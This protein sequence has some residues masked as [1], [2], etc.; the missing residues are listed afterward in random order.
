MRVLVVYAHPYPGSFCHAVLERV[1]SG[2][3]DAG[4]SHEVIDLHRSRFDPVFRNRDYNQFMHESLPD[5]LIAQA[6]LKQALVARAGGP[7][8][9]AVA[10]RWMAG[11]T[12]R[13][14]VT[15]ARPTNAAR[16]SQAPGEGRTRRRADLHRPGL[17]DG[18]AGDPQGLVRAGVRLRLR[19]HPRP[20]GL[21]RPA[22]RAG[23]AADPAEGP[24]HHADVLHRGRV[25]E[26][27]A[28][29]DGHHHLRLG[30]EDGRRARRQSTCTSTPSAPSIRRRGSNTSSARTA[31]AG[32]SPSRP[33]QPHRPP[34]KEAMV[35]RIAILVPTARRLRAG[36]ET[37]RAGRRRV[38]LRELHRGDAGQRAAEV[39][40]H[41][42]HGDP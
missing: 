9:R 6:D 19:L 2:L 38:R 33:H 5:D 32:T 4:H 22:L 1:I 26:G 18:P 41:Q 12:D 24:G 20:R 10:R 23:A 27:L 14:I 17:L 42:R 7:V 8:R 35:K 21:E 16:R 28:A 34:D 13:E 11:K 40:L 30:P 15:G 3:D 25:R 37:A 39:D 36:R 29:G 31:S